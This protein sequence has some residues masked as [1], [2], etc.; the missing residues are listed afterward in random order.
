VDHQDESATPQLTG[1]VAVVV[2]NDDAH[3]YTTAVESI[4]AFS[5]NSTTGALTFVEVE[6]D[7][8]GGV[9]GLGGASQLVVSPDD[10]HVYVVGQT[11]DAIAVFSRNTTTGEL[12]FVEALFHGVGG[13]SGLSVVH[14][15]AISSD[16][17]HV[18]TAAVGV[19]DIGIFSRNSATG[20][21]TFVDALT[22]PNNASRIA[23]SPD[24]GRLYVTG[25]GAHLDIL[26]RDS[27]T[28]LL[29]PEDGLEDDVGG[30]DGL[31]TPR[32]IAVSA[33]SQFAYVAA[34]ES[35]IA[36]FRKVTVSCSPSALGGCFEPALPGKAKLIIKDNA[37]DKGDKLIFKWL[38]GEAVTLGDFGDPIA[39]GND[40]ALCLY[41]SVGGAL[42]E[43]ELLAPAGG[44]CKKPTDGGT[45]P[46]W[47][48][49]STKGFKYARKDRHPDGV[50]PVKL[51]AGATEK[52]KV[53]VKAKG[54]FLPLP[55]LPLTL[56][57]TVQLQSA[58]GPCWTATYSSAILND[59]TLVKA[60]AD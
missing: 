7:G 43:T 35:T 10:K 1:S 30:V 16:G 19:D 28:G 5:R 48:A 22:A 32:G 52:A 9:D 54:E 44:G 42:L 37:T 33:D 46:C 8:V 11:D 60:Q 31:G 57:V 12:T 2:S 51:L 58:G 25:G 3:V 53:L 4:V 24:G 55:A 56:P 14:D 41:S 6:E 18:Y 47:K 59:G 20:E 38:K 27:G 40:Y 49:L 29:T 17:S 39:G 23:I 34:N 45:Q 15:V 21:L 26:I 36:A 50:T 13:V